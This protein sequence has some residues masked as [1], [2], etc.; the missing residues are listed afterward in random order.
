MSIYQIFFKLERDL[1]N[2]IQSNDQDYLRRIFSLVNW[3]FD[4][5]ETADGIWNAAATA[6]LE[7]MADEDER[8]ELIPNWVKPDLFADMRDEFE[9]RR[10]R[11]GAGKFK[12]LLDKY[13][14]VNNTNLE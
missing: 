4:H 3:C 8:A 9:K 1:D 11:S 13:N 5:R 7:H 6:F 14:R 2:H 10:E 12:V